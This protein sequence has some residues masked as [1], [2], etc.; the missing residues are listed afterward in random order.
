MVLKLTG[1]END[2][3]TCKVRFLLSKFKTL[4]KTNFSKDG[5]CVSSSLR[6]DQIV[7]CRDES[8]EEGC[9]MLV[10]KKSYNKRVAPFSTESETNLTIV[11]VKVKVT[12]VLMNI[13]DI[14]EVKHIITLKFGMMLE[15]YEK[16]AIYHNLKQ[17][18]TLNSLTGSEIKKLWTPYVIYKNTDKSDAVRIGEVDTTLTVTREGNFSRSPITV[19]D[20][21]ETFQGS[22]NKLTMNQTDSK[23][24]HCIYQLQTYPFDT[25]VL[26]ISKK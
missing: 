23:Q 16:R 26:G 9:A 14:E 20:E 5:Q 7:N 2:E 4:Y 1:C 8:D 22:E 25:Q 19:A 6:C 10:I 21:I 15:W 12:M 11:P 17:E 24:F 3:F 13:L 18:E